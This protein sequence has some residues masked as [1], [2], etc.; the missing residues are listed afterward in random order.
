MKGFIISPRF[1]YFEYLV[2]HEEAVVQMC[3]KKSYK[4]IG[5][6]QENICAG[7]TIFI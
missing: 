1:T 3:S 6:S 5:K 2:S 7:V 4:F